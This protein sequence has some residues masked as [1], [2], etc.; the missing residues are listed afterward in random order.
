PALRL[1]AVRSIAVRPDD[2][3]QAILRRVADDPALRFDAVSGLAHSVAT[4]EEA[5]K[6]LIGQLDGP[7]SVE[8]IRSLSGAVD[9]PE[10]RMALEKKGG[11]LAALLLGR[12]AGQPPSI[13][14]WKKV[15]A[16]KGDAAAGERLFFHAKG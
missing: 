3:A 13:D 12:P 8:A 1:E 16:E 11:E 7:A 5:R 14:G 6:V 2:A 9:R 10:V 15:A 4:S